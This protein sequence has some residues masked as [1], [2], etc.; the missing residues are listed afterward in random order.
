MR[1]LVEEL[2]IIDAQRFIAA[3]NR[4]RFDYTEWRRENLLVG[5]T[6]EEVKAAAVE[7]ARAHPFQGDA[8]RI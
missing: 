8:E 4:E 6:P 3:V 7:Y 2:G 1:C 5:L